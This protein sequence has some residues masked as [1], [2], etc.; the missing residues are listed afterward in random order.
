MVTRSRACLID[1]G[2][3]EQIDFAG[4]IDERHARLLANL[5]DVILFQRGAAAG[6]HTF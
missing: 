4:K 2:E 3:G 5:R 6:D 1:G